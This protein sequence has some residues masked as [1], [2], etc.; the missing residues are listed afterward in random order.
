MAL[1]HTYSSLCNLSSLNLDVAASSISKISTNPCTQLPSSLPSTKTFIR[2]TNKLTSSETQDLASISN[3]TSRIPNLAPTESTNAEFYT[4][5]ANGKSKY[6][7]MLRGATIGPA[8]VNETRMVLTQS[9]LKL[10]RT[11]RTKIAYSYFH[12]ALNKTYSQPKH[13][14][15]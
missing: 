12:F 1:R 15:C 14:G 11:E 5:M 8:A 6:P 10:V 9:S 2:L 3:L 13:Q 4:V 7:K